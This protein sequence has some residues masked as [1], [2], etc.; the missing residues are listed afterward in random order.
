MERTLIEAAR[1]MEGALQSG[2]P[3]AHYKGVALS[4]LKV[5]GGELFF[6]LPGART[7]G[8]RFVADAFEAGAAAAV[9]EKRYGREH[10][11]APGAWRQA[12]AVIQVEDGLEALHALTR[13]MREETP[14]KLVGITGSSGK[15]TTKEILAALLAGSFRVAKSPG[16]LNSLYGFPIALAGIPED[17]EWMVAEMGM[18][19]PGELGRLSRLARPDAVVF[20]NV[21]SA[22][23]E[24]FGT[25][26]AIAAAKAEI[27]EGLVADGLVVA[28]GDDPQVRRIVEARM[29][30][31]RGQVLFYSASGDTNAALWAENVRET[32][33]GFGSRFDLVAAGLR[34]EAQLALYGRYNVENFLA[35]AACAWALGIPLQK[36]ASAAARMAAVEGRGRLWSL[37]GAGVLVDDSYNSN[38]QAARR[39]LES[40]AQLPGN[41]HWAVLGDMLELGSAAERLHGEL[42]ASAAELGFSPVVGVGELSRGLVEGAET[43]GAEA[44]WFETAE[45]AARWAEGFVAPG[46]AVLVKGS[47]GVALE[48]V[49]EAVRRAAG[50]EGEA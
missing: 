44:H 17:T 8:H 41:R 24:S 13:A 30:E 43:G 46:D 11:N 35:A 42:G 27:L 4:S 3:E 29:L 40:A 49:S 10:P 9:V 32:E 18:S 25:L 33:G 15:T 1:I 50:A 19:E 31:R 39:A 34:E 5:S 14:R 28:N 22:H 21:G 45:L 37:A 16:N 20:T 36:I 48:K 47:R 6:A 2:A 38:P 7:D 23:L 26:E 12:G